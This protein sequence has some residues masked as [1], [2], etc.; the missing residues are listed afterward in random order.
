MTASRQIKV[1]FQSG[2]HDRVRLAAALCKTAMAAFC[3]QVVL[4]EADR[5]TAGLPLE[6]AGKPMAHPITKP[7][8]KRRSV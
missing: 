4:A 5:L 8:S 1:F 3:R 6:T 2:A 7:V